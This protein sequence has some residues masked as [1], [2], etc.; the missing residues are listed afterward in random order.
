MQN[1]EVKIYHEMVL[2]W[3]DS[4]KYN[5]GRWSFLSQV[6]EQKNVNLYRKGR[7]VQSKNMYIKFLH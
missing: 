5:K 4:I 7:S 1:N 3:I 2:D 6:S